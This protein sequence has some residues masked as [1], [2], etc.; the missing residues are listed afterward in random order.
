MTSSDLDLVVVVA[1]AMTTTDYWGVGRETGAD[2]EDTTAGADL[3]PDV[4]AV[5][6]T[7]GVVTAS[8]RA[9]YLRVAAEGIPHHLMYSIVH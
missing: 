6:V 7:V 5:R 4:G 3:D 2:V 1:V 9:A 8:L